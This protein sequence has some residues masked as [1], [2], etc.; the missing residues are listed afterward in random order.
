VAAEVACESK[1]LKNVIVIII[2]IIMFLTLKRKKTCLVSRRLMTRL[3]EIPK[4]LQM[5]LPLTL[6]PFL[7][8]FVLHILL[9]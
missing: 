7:T 3:L 6:N 8:Q 5:L 1:E 4:I 2:I 9:V